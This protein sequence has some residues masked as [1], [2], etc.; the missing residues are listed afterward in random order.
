MVEE[1]LAWAKAR[2][3]RVAW[4]PAEVAGDAASEVEGR[5]RSGELDEGLFEAELA[6]VVAAGKQAAAG[7]VVVV[8]VPRPAH[9][10]HFE[11]DGGL[12]AALLPPTYV[13]YRAVFED[14]RQELARDGLPG[15]RVEHLTAPLK[16]TAARLGLVRYGRNNVTYVPG[17]GSY[18]Q[19]CGYLTD[20]PL[21]P[22][23]E[24]VRRRPSLLDEC[25]RCGACVGVCPT[26]AIGDERVLMSAQRC[27]TYANE[28]PGGWP[29]FVPDW[30]H[31]CLLGCLECQAV[32]PV[33]PELTVEETGL[34]FSAA[35][36]RALLVEDDG[37]DARAESGIAL[38]M[39][40]LGQ[41]YAEPVLGR[42]LRALLGMAG[43]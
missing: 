25:E 40:W 19:L 37:G 35:E 42:N 24:P 29:A 13:R 33:N 2:G 36:T 1:L 16:A 12:T 11:L 39:A 30:A 27:L 28:V 17:A 32:C 31:T 41:P 23:E 8:A 43:P 4:G 9:R 26:K 3:Y 5:R 18:I 38:K 7:T 10:V 20:A 14:V 6:T 15:A 34:V 21:P 22:L